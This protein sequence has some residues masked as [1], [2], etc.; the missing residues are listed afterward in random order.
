MYP[1]LK[2]VLLLL[3]SIALQLG[4][5]PP[6][7]PPERSQRVGYRGQ[8]FEYAVYPLPL[9][10][11]VFASIVSVFHVA[12]IL[13]LEY[14]QPATTARLLPLVCPAPS[15]SLVRLAALTPRFTTGIAL[16]LA[17]ALL[18]VWCYRALG[19]LFTYEVALKA[20][21]HLVTGGPYA[22]VRHPSYPALWTM[23]AAALVAWYAPGGY[24]HEC[25][26]MDTRVAPFVHA[27]TAAAAC[28]A[29]GLWRRAPVEDDAMQSQ[30]GTAWEE[31]RRRVPWRFVPYVV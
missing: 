5:T 19:S 3:A 13:L 23:L 18:R 17:G 4:L 14:A 11:R 29:V 27:W 28:I 9:Y 31:Y 25:G 10:L 22:Y 12:A 20:E 16:V 2:S 6:T 1:I 15:P 30:F 7:P 26:A 24:L 21:H 8:L